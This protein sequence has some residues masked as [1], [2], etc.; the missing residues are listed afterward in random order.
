MMSMEMELIEY[1]YRAKRL[2]VMVVIAFMALS[3]F[4]LHGGSES[5]SGGA[6]ACDDS[7][8]R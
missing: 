2:V 1:E 4:V 6:D 7:G 8:D 5:A 3:A